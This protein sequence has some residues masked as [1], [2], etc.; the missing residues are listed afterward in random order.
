[1]PPPLLARALEAVAARFGVAPG[2]EV[3]IEADPGTFDA[4]RLREYRAI[5]FTRLSIG[6]QSFEEVPPARRRPIRLVFR[7]ARA[8]APQSPAVVAELTAAESPDLSPDT[9]TTTTNPNAARKDLLRTCGRAHTASAAR[10]ALSAASASPFPTWSLDLMSGLPGLSRASWRAT[11]A[12]AV[13][14]GAPHISV[15]DLQ[16]EEGTPFARRYA[17][18]AAPLPADEEAA[19]MYA[20]ASEVLSAAGYEHYEVCGGVGLGA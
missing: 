17:P 13:A 12:E 14:R 4:A 16:V 5:G 15:Y 19:A 20:D 1:V 10:A 2:A 9:K 6:V 7:Q 11:L 8:P 18:G 3:T